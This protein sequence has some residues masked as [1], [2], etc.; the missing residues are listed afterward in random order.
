MEPRA[1]K[2]NQITTLSKHEEHS[3]SNTFDSRT[4]ERSTGVSE[5]CNMS[6]IHTVEQETQDVSNKTGATIKDGAMMDKC[7]CFGFA[8]F[9]SGFFLVLVPGRSRKL[10]GISW[11][12]VA[13]VS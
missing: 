4:G 13:V 6:V 3:W 5:G 2:T 1:S 7:G 11:L 9:G 10:N 12:D 8:R